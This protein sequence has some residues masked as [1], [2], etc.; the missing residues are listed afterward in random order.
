MRIMQ[1]QLPTARFKDFK[2]LR[3]QTLNPRQRICVHKAC[4][5]ECIAMKTVAVKC[6][7]VV[8][9]GQAPPEVT[10]VCS[11]LTSAFSPKVPWKYSK[12]Q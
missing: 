6:L 2:L 10:E 3:S 1:P 7:I 11:Q 12:S 8:D 5:C 4:C 9:E